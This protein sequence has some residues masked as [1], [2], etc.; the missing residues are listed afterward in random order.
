MKKIEIIIPDRFVNDVNEI[1]KEIHGGGM[2]QYRVEGR[3]KVKAKPVA[4]DRG[5]RQFTPE[6]VPRTKIEVI[7]KDDQVE[8]ILDRISAKI[9][10]PNAGGKIF[11]SEVTAALDLG[12]S[13]TGDSAL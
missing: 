6:S 8:G 10:D 11:V 2:T 1:I 5:T 4:I 7:V 9:R 13:A 3:G 12:T